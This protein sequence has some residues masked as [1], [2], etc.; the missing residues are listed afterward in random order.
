MP[1]L[2]E[3]RIDARFLV[4]VDVLVNVFFGQ[5]ERLDSLKQI[6]MT[7]IQADLAGPSLHKLGRAM[8]GDE[9]V[10]VVPVPAFAINGFLDADRHRPEPWHIRP[11]PREEPDEHALHQRR[12]RQAEVFVLVFGVPKRDIGHLRAFGLDDSNR[13]TARNDK[14]PAAARRDEMLPGERVAVLRRPN[15]AVE[16]EIQPIL[17]Q[18]IRAI[19]RPEHGRPSLMNAAPLSPAEARPLKRRYGVFAAK[20]ARRGS[21]PDGSR[22]RAARG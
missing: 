20:P 7:G 6:Q 11:E 13:M 9:V 1:G 19:L 22:P 3:H 14:A 17:R 18:D 8:A 16:I 12:S 2:T 10:M 15:R 4:D 5:R 21:E